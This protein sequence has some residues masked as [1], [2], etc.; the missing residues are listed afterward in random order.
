VERDPA[1]LRIARAQSPEERERR[2]DFVRLFKRSPIPDGELLAQLGLYLNRQTLSRILFMHE[3]YSRIVDVPGIV[4]EL[5]V[6]WGQ[7]LALFS[8][9]RG[10]RNRS[11]TRGGS[12][13]STPSQTSDRRR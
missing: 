6:R 9:F 1:E 12:S 13:A 7:N 3:L 2:G 4:V 11:T 10:W 8:S 5:G